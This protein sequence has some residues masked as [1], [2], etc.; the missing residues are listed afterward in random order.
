LHVHH[1]ACL[2]EWLRSHSSCPVCKLDLRLPAP[3]DAAGRAASSANEVSSSSESQGGGRRELRFRL[4]ELESLAACELKYLST[5]LGMDV[6]RGAE[7]AELELAI[8]GSAR[9][10]ILCRREELRLLPVARLRGLLRSS[11]LGEQ[12]PALKEKAELIDA[13]LESGRYVEDTAPPSGSYDAAPDER[14][15]RVRAAPY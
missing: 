12:L 3:E 14:P 15:Q 13:L 5:F 7:R 11:G 4:R 9:V 6:P 10:R 1:A 8:S 2:A